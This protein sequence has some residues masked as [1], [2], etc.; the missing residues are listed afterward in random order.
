MRALD[1]ACSSSTIG[2]MEAELYSVS[3]TDLLKTY[4][5]VEISPKMGWKRGGSVWFEAENE[6]RLGQVRVGG[7]IMLGA[8]S[9]S[10]WCTAIF[11]SAFCV[12]PGHRKV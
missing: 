12:C 3:A 4:F 2:V 7:W 5:T 11:T 1:V 6:T 10:G 8:E 9:L